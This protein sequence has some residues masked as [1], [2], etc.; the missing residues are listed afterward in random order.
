MHFR[1]G[2]EVHFSINTMQFFNI[3]I[4]I[5]IRVL[6]IIKITF[7]ENKAELQYYRLS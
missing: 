3:P 7:E 1:N 2:Q 5:V 6:W 4:S